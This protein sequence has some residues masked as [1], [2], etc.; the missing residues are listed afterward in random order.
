GIAVRRRK[1]KTQG[2]SSI[3]R[4]TLQTQIRCYAGTIMKSRRLRDFRRRL[5]YSVGA[6][7]LSRSAA[8]RNWNELTTPV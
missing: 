1:T 4:E 8:L 6:Y 2:S 7:L 3:T 5:G